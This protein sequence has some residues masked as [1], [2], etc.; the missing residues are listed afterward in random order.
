MQE[1]WMWSLGQEAPLEEGMTTHS[2]LLARMDSRGQHT[3]VQTLS[4]VILVKS[5]SPPS[6]LCSSIMSGECFQAHNIFKP[7]KWN[8]IKQSSSS[9]V[10]PS[11]WQ[12]LLGSFLIL[13]MHLCICHI[14]SI[15]R[16]YAYF[17]YQGIRQ[18]FYSIMKCLSF[19]LFCKLF[20]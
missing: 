18:Q 14:L 1:T 19:F 5:L 2:T 7:I 15:K 16:Q 11:K 4:A 13:L 6:L 20:F 3:W 8:P 17:N 9:Q 10:S 12:R